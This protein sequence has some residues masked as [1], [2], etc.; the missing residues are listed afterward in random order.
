MITTTTNSPEA[1][2]HFQK[3]EALF[4]NLRT[5]E[6]AK[7]FDAALKLDPAF[8]LAHAFHGLSVPGPEGLKEIE[9]AAAAA[10]GLPEAERTLIEG[11]A[12]APA[13]RHGEVD[14]ALH[15]GR[16]ADAG[17]LAQPLRARPAAAVRAEGGRGGARS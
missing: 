3:G 17:R 5:D 6:A 8:P 10:S 15:Q 9:A 12:A 1:L 2:A 14:R 13:R 11:T 7:E 4:H 16:R